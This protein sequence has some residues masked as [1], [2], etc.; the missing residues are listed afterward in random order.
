M[1]LES[2]NQK[3][4]KDGNIN[5]RHLQHLLISSLLSAFVVVAVVVVVVVVI[6]VVGVGG[7]C[8]RRSV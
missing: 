1:E 5:S 3:T 8:L 4:I 7:R 2:N 6:A